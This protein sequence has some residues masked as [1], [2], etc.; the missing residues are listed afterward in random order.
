MKNIKKILI[1][2]ALISCFSMSAIGCDSTNSEDNNTSAE[3]TTGAEVDTDSVDDTAEESADTEEASQDDTSI[4]DDTASEDTTSAD[5]E[6]TEENADETVEETVAVTDA[7]GNQVTDSDGN[8][9]TDIVIVNKN[10]SSA[11]TDANNN[12]SNNAQTEANA[13]QNSNNNQEATT[14]E[15]SSIY[16]AKNRYTTFLWMSNDTLNR[17]YS[18]AMAEVTFKVLDG[19]TAGDYPVE[20]NYVE[21]Y[22]TNG[23][24]VPFTVQNGTITV[25]SAKSVTEQGAAA[26]GVNY[27][28]DNATA[29]PGDTVTLTVYIDNNSGMAIT[30]VELKYD[31]NA[32]EVQ[33][34]KSTGDFSSETIDYNPNGEKSSRK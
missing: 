17:T 21:I 18:G 27:R 16:F 6:S 1:C 4:A 8:V 13:D 20:F 11:Q 2:V 32:L 10:G 15:D 26:S 34:L 28:I 29:Q 9:V 22:D 7:D 23:E 24:A 31:N 25:G 5:G 12:D 33:S 30:K 3:V 14:T 19:A